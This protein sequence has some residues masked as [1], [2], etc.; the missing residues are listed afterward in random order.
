MQTFPTINKLRNREIK[1]SLLIYII[2]I[3]KSYLNTFLVINLSKTRIRSYL[4]F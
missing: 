2:I 3:L 4:N 1:I